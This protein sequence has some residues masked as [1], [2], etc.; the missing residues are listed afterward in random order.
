MGSG[1]NVRVIESG[2]FKHEAKTQALYLGPGAVVAGDAQ[3]V[4]PRQYDAP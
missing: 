4:H 1:L 2:D 3:H